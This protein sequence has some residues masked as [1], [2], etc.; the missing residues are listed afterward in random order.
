MERGGTF[1][2]FSK[3]IFFIRPE[4]YSFPA[5]FSVTSIPALTVRNA[6][7]VFAN[8]TTHE[9]A[10]IKTTQWNARKLLKKWEGGRIRRYAL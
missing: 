9:C 4:F 6:L 5:F 7:T 3:V 1:L 2:E 8:I 10:L